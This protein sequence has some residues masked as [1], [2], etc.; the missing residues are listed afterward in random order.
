MKKCAIFFFI[1]CILFSSFTLL[2]SAHPGRTDSNGGHYN[3]DTGEYHYHSG[4][5]AG[6]FQS[7]NNNPSDIDN[8]ILSNSDLNSVNSEFSFFKKLSVD[9]QFSFL[10]FLHILYSLLCVFLFIRIY[11]LERCNN[12]LC[13]RSEN[14]SFFIPNKPIAIIE[15]TTLTILLTVFSLSCNLYNSNNEIIRDLIFFLIPLVASLS[16]GFL[17]FL[18]WGIFFVFFIIFQTFV[19]M[20]KEL[21][22]LL[23]NKI[24]NYSLQFANQELLSHYK[25][26]AEEENTPK[27]VDNQNEEN[28]NPV[29]NKDIHTNR[30]ENVILFEPDVSQ[31]NDILPP[32]TSAVKKAESLIP[33]F[34]SPEVKSKAEHN[35]NFSNKYFIGSDIPA[36]TYFFSPKD[37]NTPAFFTSKSYITNITKPKQ[38]FFL[39]EGEHIFLFNCYLESE[40]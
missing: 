17:C 29:T 14:N 12:K 5:Y 24:S 9:Y 34:I 7:S 3:H 25:K 30:S 36:G 23:K 4:K 19:D 13:I 32:K 22:C 20:L 31:Q 6:L 39:A 21:F 27:Q 40:E 1:F 15:L 10:D 8:S 18:F 38:R 16:F 37:H 11:L 2:A 33:V 35:K 28:K 26:I